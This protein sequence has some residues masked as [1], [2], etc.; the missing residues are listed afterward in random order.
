MHRFLYLGVL[1]PSLFGSLHGESL[2]F[3]DDWYSPIQV[4]Y[5]FSD[6]LFNQGL[7]ISEIDLEETS[8]IAAIDPIKIDPNHSHVKRTLSKSEEAAAFIKAL[9]DIE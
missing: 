2:D 5:D 9:L 7:V 6:N 8:A 3:A 1:L 4:A